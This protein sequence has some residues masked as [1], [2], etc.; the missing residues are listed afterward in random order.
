MVKN[1]KI[2][3][4]KLILGLMLCCQCQFYVIGSSCID[5][6]LFWESPSFISLCWP[7]PKFLRFNKN[8][9]SC[10]RNVA[11]A[12]HV[13]LQNW[14]CQRQIVEMATNIQ[15]C[16]QHRTRRMDDQETF[17]FNEQCGTLTSIIAFLWHETTIS[18][19]INCNTCTNTLFSESRN[20]PD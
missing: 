16:N 8:S 7:F 4:K 5:I 11:H 10:F 1:K 18:R 9:K 2:A 17:V 6:K 19:C 15:K 12:K 20:E 13:E 3:P 14:Q